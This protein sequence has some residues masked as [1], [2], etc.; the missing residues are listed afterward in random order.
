MAHKTILLLLFCVLAINEIYGKPIRKEKEEKEHPKKEEEAEY[1]R[2]LGQVVEILEEDDEFK[3][4]LHN[5]SEDEIRS[6]AIADHI[7]LVSHKVRSKLDELKRMEIEFQKRLRRQERDHLNGINERNFWSP[8]FDENSDTFEQEDLKKL[9]HKHNI[10]M[11]EQDKKRREDFHKY[12]LEKEH[13]RRE[14]MKNLSE[15]D[16]KKKEAEHEDELKKLRKHEKMHEPGSKA[17]LEEVWKEEDGLDPESFDPKTF[18]NLHDKNGDGYLDFFELQTFFLNDV[19]KVYNESDPNTDPR[20]RQEELERMREHVMKQMDKDNDGLVSKEEFIKSTNDPEFEKDD[21]WKPVVDDEEYSEDELKEYEKQLEEE[22][23]RNREGHHGENNE[24]ES[25]EHHE[26]PE[27]V[28]VEEKKDEHHAKQEQAQQQHHEQPKQQQQQHDQQQQ[29][30]NE[31]Q[32]QQTQQQ[33][34]H[35]EQQQQQQHEQ[36]QPGS[37]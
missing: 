35:H 26:K 24:H 12:E 28:H 25:D 5:A 2:Y 15:E 10:M 31:Q 3:K 17:E 36:Q 30:H 23:E 37:H 27:E 9:L 34:Q 20:E 21:E 33:P 13:K 32:Q 22:A 19:D 18:F 11:E 29:Q 8:L 4:K 7:D 16:R 1:L 14:E 6:G